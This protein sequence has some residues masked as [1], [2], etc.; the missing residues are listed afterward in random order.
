M[1]FLDPSPSTVRVRTHLS[2][3]W[4]PQSGEHETQAWCRVYKNGE[5]YGEE[6]TVEWCGNPPCEETW[7][8]DLE[9]QQGDTIELWVR[10]ESGFGASADM[11]LCGD[12]GTIRDGPEYSL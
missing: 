9:F 6:H 11:K 10:T 3:S 5:P 2:L 7:N 12:L 8:E 1:D 4:N